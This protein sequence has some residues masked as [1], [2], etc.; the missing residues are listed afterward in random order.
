MKVASLQIETSSDYSVPKRDPAFGRRLAII[1]CSLI[2]GFGGGFGAGW[3]ARPTERTTGRPDDV[4]VA[5][6]EAFAAVSATPDTGANADYIPILDNWEATTSQQ[7]SGNFAIG[8]ALLQAGGG[9]PHA[10]FEGAMWIS[11]CR[12][13]RFRRRSRWEQ[14]A[15]QK[16]RR[17]AAAALQRSP[18]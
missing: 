13:S 14:C 8:A 3:G 16:L 6:S 2:V 4:R 17:L 5:L 10:F 15:P 12:S 9:A 18:L 7:S 1:L 11:A